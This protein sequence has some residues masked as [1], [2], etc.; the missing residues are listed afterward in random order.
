MIYGLFY[1]GPP[2]CPGIICWPG[3]ISGDFSMIDSHSTI[4]SSS[5]RLRFANLRPLQNRRPLILLSTG[6]CRYTIA[7]KIAN[8][9]TATR[10]HTLRQNRNLRHRRIVSRSFCPQPASLTARSLSKSRIASQCPTPSYR[11]LQNRQLRHP[12]QRPL[13]PSPEPHRRLFA[14]PCSRPPVRPVR[15][16]LVASLLICYILSVRQTPHR[17]EPQCE[18]SRIGKDGVW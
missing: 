1:P 6:R 15:G 17:S 4:R 18:R 10:T 2:L 7:L 8:C 12:Q 14:P 9:V 3:C 5:A 13:P 11:P 16:R